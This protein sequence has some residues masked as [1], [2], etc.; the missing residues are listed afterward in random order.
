MLE[1][2]KSRESVL[3]GRE[4]ENY[5]AYLN[6]TSTYLSLLSS[7]KSSNADAVLRTQF[8]LNIY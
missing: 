1:K 7:I 4:A 3:E 2:I 8:N 5:I 6:R